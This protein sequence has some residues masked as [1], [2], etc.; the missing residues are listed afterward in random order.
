MN[1]LSL[2]EATYIWR[3]EKNNLILIEAVKEIDN[4]LKIIMEKEDKFFL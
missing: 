2:E 1:E 4:H 3:T